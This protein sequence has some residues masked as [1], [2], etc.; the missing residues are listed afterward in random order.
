MKN[1]AFLYIIIFTFIL[2]SI[3]LGIV[4]AFKKDS[5][6]QNALL[7]KAEQEIK[8]LEGKNISM[9]NKLNKINFLDSVLTEEKTKNE[10]ATS[11]EEQTQK[12]GESS[13]TGSETSQSSSKNSGGSSSESSSKN[14]ETSNSNENTIYEVKKKRYFSEWSQW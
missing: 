5:P 7:E 14:N 6:D 4:F 3:G 12:G 11:Q 9:L 1:K 8:F 10:K 13:K 2:L